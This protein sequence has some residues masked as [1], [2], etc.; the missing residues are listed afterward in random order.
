MDLAEI[1]ERVLIYVSWPLGGDSFFFSKVILL[2]P[3]E[4]M[5]V[6]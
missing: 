3:F 4:Y 6:R 5:I 2:L 1:S